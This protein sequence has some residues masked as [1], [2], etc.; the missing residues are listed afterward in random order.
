MTNELTVI[1]PRTLEEASTLSKQL[2]KAKTLPD[3]L[4]QSEADILAI[5]LTGAELGLAP[6]QAIRGIQ[7]IKGRPTLSADA[8]GALVKSRR[9]V[10]E[11][12]M[13]QH[14]DAQIARYVTKRAG[15]PRPVEMA[16][17]ADDASRAGLGGDNWK[18]YPAAMLR[19]RALSSICRAVYPDLILGVYDPD[20]PL[21]E[22]AQPQE[23]A[24]E[25]QPR[26]PRQDVVD[27]EVKPSKEVESAKAVL[28]ST[29]G[30]VETPRSEFV[31]PSGSQKGKRLGEVDDEV[32]RKLYA[33]YKGLNLA[34]VESGDE[35]KAV[36][37]LDVLAAVDDELH[38]RGIDAEA[39]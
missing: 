30:F 17:S 6:M 39:V 24:V 2:S 21:N 26:K 10:C 22:V 38:R 36:N 29:V 3:A 4:K 19:A 14:S 32:L 20:E 16:F 9:D 15:D 27:V 5:V 33:H 35:A 25:K 12:L 13:L 18:K 8:M 23:P 37:A 1:S 34:A 7:I 11:Y 31:I 28:E